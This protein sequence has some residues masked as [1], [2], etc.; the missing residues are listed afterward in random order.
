MNRNPAE[1]RV[2]SVRVADLGDRLRERGPA[3]LEERDDPGLTSPVSSPIVARFPAAAAALISW[4][5]DSIAAS[6]ESR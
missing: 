3:L 6:P 5:A 2:I 1:A 4:R